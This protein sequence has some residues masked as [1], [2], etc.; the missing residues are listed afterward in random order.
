MLIHIKINEELKKEL[1][2]EAEKKGHSLNAYI[3]MI[4]I[5]RRK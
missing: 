5:E 4:L 1:K 2:E 3:R